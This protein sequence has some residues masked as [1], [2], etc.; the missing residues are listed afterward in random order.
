MER[1]V[2][3]FQIIKSPNYQIIFLLRKMKKDKKSLGGLIYSTNPGFTPENEGE[4]EPD[5]LPNEKQR[6]KI[7]LDKK[8][9]GGKEVT[10]V[11]GFVGKAEDLEILGKQLKNKCGSGGSVKDNEII[12]Q[13]D[14]RE[15]VTNFLRSLGYTVK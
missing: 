7:A 1:S 4:D 3:N 8:N 15:L 2:I 14:K 9:R 10:L 6:L 13:G 11:T 5:T 12:I